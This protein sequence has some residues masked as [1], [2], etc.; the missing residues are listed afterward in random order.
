MASTPASTKEFL[1]QQCWV[2]SSRRNRLPGLHHGAG[3]DWSINDRKRERR[4]YNPGQFHVEGSSHIS[5]EQNVDDIQAREG[6]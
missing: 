3:L 4:G 5:G 6:S 2:D 1:L